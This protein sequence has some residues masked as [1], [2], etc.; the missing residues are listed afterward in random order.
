MT[1]ALIQ[2][3]SPNSAYQIQGKLSY[4]SSLSP[5]MKMHFGPEGLSLCELVFDIPH[6]STF[7][8]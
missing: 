7:D 8:L 3:K 2:E 5:E 4:K 6:L 1:F